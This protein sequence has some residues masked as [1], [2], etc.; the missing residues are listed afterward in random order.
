LSRSRTLRGVLA[1]GTAALVLAACSSAPTGPVATVDGTEIP[2][3]QLAVWIRTATDANSDIDAVGLQ[4]DLLSRVIQKQIIDALVAELG[5]TVDPSLVDGIRLAI[6]QQV[7]GDEA[8]AATLIDVGF[9]VDYFEDVFLALEANIDTLVSELAKGLTLETRTAR[10]ILVGTAAEAD[11]V[12]ALLQDGADFALLAIE[13]STDQGSGARG[14]DLGPQQRGAYVPPFDAA[15][16]SA[17]LDTVLAP[18]ESEFGFH[19]IEVTAIETTPSERLDPQVRRSLVTAELQQLVTAAFG[20]ADVS[21][22]PTIGVWN[23]QTGAIVPS[24]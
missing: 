16:W 1:A 23:P 19:V 5:L 18:V 24:S 4:A 13:L 3:E 7:G 12:F 20:A 11:E 6:A 21:L 17:P 22:D 8:L 2:R 14:G 10:H 9:P 15:V